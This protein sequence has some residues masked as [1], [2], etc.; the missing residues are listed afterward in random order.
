MHG[1]PFTCIHGYLAAAWLCC[2]TYLLAGVK[3]VTGSVPVKTCKKMPGRSHQ[4]L[5]RAF[6]I[7][8]F[9]KVLVLQSVFF[10]L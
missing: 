4:D 7:N 1:Y 8:M 5:C 2:C 9:Y 10:L 6:V 3:T